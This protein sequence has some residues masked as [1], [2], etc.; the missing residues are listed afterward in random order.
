MAATLTAYIPNSE[1]T[2]VTS[3]MGFIDTTSYLTRI[4]IDG[5]G[6]INATLTLSSGF[7]IGQL[8]KIQMIKMFRTGLDRPCI[9]LELPI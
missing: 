9:T 3:S 1:I 8:K 7:V 2:E 5:I 4:N 6:P